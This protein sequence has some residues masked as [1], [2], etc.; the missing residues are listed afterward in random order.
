ME[1]TAL[2]LPADPAG[3]VM[4]LRQAEWDPQYG[5]VYIWFK[6]C[7]AFPVFGLEARVDGNRK[8]DAVTFYSSR[9]TQPTPATV[10]ALMGGVEPGYRTISAWE[11]VPGR[12]KVKVAE[13]AIMVKP[14]SVTYVPWF[15]PSASP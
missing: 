13:Q 3:N 6:S 12:G 4:H 15:E 2:V 5:H 7:T 9:D 1:D 8:P 11:D 14:G 10:L